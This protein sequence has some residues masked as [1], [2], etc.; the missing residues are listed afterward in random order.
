M[1]KVKV[2]NLVKKL[3][4]FGQNRPLKLHSNLNIIIKILMMK[5]EVMVTALC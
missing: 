4:K 3:L 1:V 5:P 2:L